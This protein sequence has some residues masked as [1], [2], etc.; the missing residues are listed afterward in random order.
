MP[1]ILIWASL[2]ALCL[3]FS[4]HAN[5]DIVTIDFENDLSQTPVDL[6]ESGISLSMLSQTTP[7]TANVAEDTSGLLTISIIGATSNDPTNSFVNS[8]NASLGINSPGGVDE[9]DRFD[10]DFGESLEFAFNFDVDLVSVDF[11]NLSGTEELTFH[12]VTGIN[13]DN[14]NG[15]DLFTFAGDGIFVPAGTPIL[16]EATEG[17]FGLDALTIHV[18][19]AV[20]PEPSSLSLLG[21]VSL[22]AV[23]R[24][25]RSRE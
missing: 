8:T 20:V 11:V 5:A 7:L 21:L 18:K 23:S 24:R 3:T 14:T 10:A 15:S 12:T 13:D 17:N 6:D 4:S 2:I 9:S 19:T 16:I 22:F 1:R 25:R